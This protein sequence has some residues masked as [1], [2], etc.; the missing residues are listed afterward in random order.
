MKKVIRNIV[1]WGMALS[2][3]VTSAVSPAGVVYAAEEQYESDAAIEDSNEEYDIEVTDENPEYEEPQ[4]EITEE[5]A[6]EEE[7][8]ETGLSDDEILLFDDGDSEEILIEDISGNSFEEG[9][10]GDND[11][12]DFQADSSNKCGDNATW[13]FNKSTGVLTISGKGDMYDYSEENPAPWYGKEVKG[14]KVS[15][16][17]TRIGNY[18]FYKSINWKNPADSIYLSKTLKSIGDFAFAYTYF[19]SKVEKFV[20]PDSVTELGKGA[21]TYCQLYH[22][23]TLS[24]EE[25]GA[26]F[27]LGKGVKVIPQ[28]CFVGAVACT[29]EIPE[30]LE[31][32]EDKGMYFFQGL[33]QFV[34]PKSLKYI[35][36][37]GLGYDKFYVLADSDITFKGDMP[38]FGKDCFLHRCGFVFYPSGNKTYTE[39]TIAA[40]QKLSDYGLTWREEGYVPSGKAGDNITWKT[41]SKKEDKNT[42]KILEFTG[43]GLMYD[44]S[45][46]NLPDWYPD[47]VSVD[48]ILLDSRITSI[49]N[50]AFFSMQNV[51]NISSKK[52]PLVLPTNLEKIGDYAFDGAHIPRITMPSTC[53]Y[54][55][56]Y[57]FAYSN[58]SEA[59]SNVFPKGVKHIGA[60]AFYSST[61]T[62]DVKWDKIEF[63]GEG[64]FRETVNMTFPAAFPGT[65]KTVKCIAFAGSK[66]L[67][68]K[69]ELPSIETMGENAFAGTNVKELVLGENL[70]EIIKNNT[71]FYH[72][73]G[74]KF[75]TITFK[76]P[77]FSGLYDFFGFL[78]R[79]KN[80]VT[81]N[82][83]AGKNWP[84]SYTTRFDNI[85]FAIYGKHNIKFIYPDKSIHDIQVPVGQKITA[86]TVTGLAEGVKIIGWF[87]GSQPNKADEWDFNKVP[88]QDVTL[89]AFTNQVECTV[90]YLVPIYPDK[91]GTGYYSKDESSVKYGE[92]A[93]NKRFSMKGFKLVGWYEDK[94][95]TKAYDFSAPVKYNTTLYSKWKAVEEFNFSTATNNIKYDK[96]IYAVFDNDYYWP[97][98]KISANFGDGFELLEKGVDYTLE[99][100]EGNKGAGFLDVGDFRIIVKGIG[101]CTGEL[102]IYLHITPLDISTSKK[103]RPLKDCTAIYDGKEHKK[104]QEIILEEED[105]ISFL[106]EKN[107]KIEF[108]ESGSKNPFVDAGTYTVRVTGINNCKGTLEYKQIIQPSSFASAYNIRGT[109]QVTY[110]YNKKVQ[111]FKPDPVFYDGKKSVALKEGVDYTVEYE[112]ESAAGAFKEP[113][114]YR[115]KVTGIGNFKDSYTI[116]ERISDGQ[117][118][119]KAT[120][121][122]VK[123][124]AFTGKPNKM[125]GLTVKYKGKVLTEGEHYS[126]KYS[127][128]TNAGTGS[129]SIQGIDAGGFYGTKTVTFKITPHKI[130]KSDVEITGLSSDRVYTGSEIKADSLKIKSN[131]GGNSYELSGDYDY[132]CEYKKNVNAG[133]ATLV[134]R[135]IN[136]YSGTIKK[137]FKIKAAELNENAVSQGRI[138]V[139]V[140]KSK[141]YT[142]GKTV[143]EPK[144]YYKPQGGS[145]VELVKGKDYSLTYT[146]NSKVNDGLGKKAPTVKIKG[147]KNFKGTITRTFAITPSSIEVC[148]VT[149]KNVKYQN[150]A[151]N[152]K[153]AVVVKDTNGSKLKAGKDYEVKYYNSA[154]KKELTAKDKALA[155]T[156]IAIVITGLGNYKSEKTLTRYYTIVK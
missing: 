39:K 6:Y 10:A 90:K 58:T 67:P 65:L 2:M 50:Y 5:E 137:T 138:I 151:N 38:Q 147:T 155:G 150:K 9:T 42:V 68:D 13:S 114:T 143:V 95:F 92:C 22:A 79:G 93:S 96:D 80:R 87:T 134:I 28:E 21:F 15:D 78:N 91:A 19:S 120:V 23:S 123:D 98:P 144:V 156:Q 11:D 27:I 101:N 60:H 145:K 18:A 51:N 135:G 71:G 129:I 4:D 29:L 139:D 7:A 136:N 140:P 121:S 14:I 66:G 84:Y 109:K 73:M 142:K 99:Y 45:L 82:Y 133:T 106:N 53:G 122:G 8:L 148:E 70:S 48:R 97:N 132:T 25:V 76:C 112:N 49:G 153:A 100:P 86:P 149:V 83:P 88:V 1:L 131:L 62:L 117:P 115:I 30:G 85:D 26:T 126:V 24:E 146:N 52:N 119:S 154:T 108:I 44:Y 61:M 152:F 59:T 36:E 56:D 72:N 105:G 35:G 128:N 125:T 16:G 118:I 141:A 111:K 69:V 103:I 116:V 124:C 34:F 110:E 54:I 57:A 46:T 37:K 64:A 47:R 127:N 40:A 104:S 77:W 43:T 130:A 75:K 94:E 55:G 102:T 63:I 74:D 81:L 32:I 41:Y 17:I 33:N 107:Y 31:R 89:V 3:S 12:A 113:G 20:V